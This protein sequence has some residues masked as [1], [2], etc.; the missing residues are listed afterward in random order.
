MPHGGGLRQQQSD[1]SLGTGTRVEGKEKEKE[2]EEEKEDHGRIFREI[3]RVKFQPF[4]A[5][6]VASEC[7]DL[8]VADVFGDEC[9]RVSLKDGL[10]EHEGSQGQSPPSQTH[11]CI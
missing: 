2:K 6:A 4:K 1:L 8:T 9:L 11:D 10:Q 7:L 3:R 5:D